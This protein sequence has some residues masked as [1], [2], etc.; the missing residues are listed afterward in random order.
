MEP[1]ELS[2]KSAATP[3]YKHTKEYK[4]IQHI[5]N[6]DEYPEYY[7][8]DM[9]DEY[10]EHVKSP[11]HAQIIGLLLNYRCSLPLFIL[12]KI[13]EKTEN[14]KEADKN[15]ITSNVLHNQRLT[16]EFIKKYLHRIKYIP[17][18]H[19]VRVLSDEF[20]EQYVLTK[21]I[22]VH[23]SLIIMRELSDEKAKKYF[24]HFRDNGIDIS[25]DLVRRRLPNQNCRYF[26]RDYPYVVKTKSEGI[27]EFEEFPEE[28]A[29]PKDS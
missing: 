12:D 1:S 16:E 28:T 3:D 10:F 9:L 29:N 26:R 25:K 22:N 13:M 8:E 2:T 27:L 5:K 18:L 6:F 17:T 19:N 4:I 7:Y 15:E 21:K 24:Q 23:P 20:I 11:H 14:L